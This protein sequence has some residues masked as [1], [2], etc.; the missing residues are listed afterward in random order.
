M[1][2]HGCA[3]NVTLG[4]LW[5]KCMQCGKWLNYKAKALLQRHVTSAIRPLRGGE[6]K[7]LHLKIQHVKNRNSQ[8]YTASSL[9]KQTLADTLKRKEKYP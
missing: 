5:I 2:E 1:A 7:E 3:C 9:K 6:M 8:S 4:N